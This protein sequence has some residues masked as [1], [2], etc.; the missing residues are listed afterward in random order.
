VRKD[1]KVLVVDTRGLPARFGA[2]PADRGEVAVTVAATIMGCWV[3][4]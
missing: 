4:A 1:N 3:G 2:P